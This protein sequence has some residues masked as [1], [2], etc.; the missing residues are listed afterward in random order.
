MVRSLTGISCGVVIGAV[1]PHALCVVAFPVT[2]LVFCGLLVGVLFLRV[3]DNRGSNFSVMFPSVL[4]GAALA[5]ASNT[6][7]SLAYDSNLL[8]VHLRQAGSCR[9]RVRGRIVQ[10][11]SVTGR[12]VSLEVALQDTL[13]SSESEEKLVLPDVRGWVRVRITRPRHRSEEV[14]C[15]YGELTGVYAYGDVV[16]ING[17]ASLPEPPRNPNAFSLPTYF[18]EQR[19]HAELTADIKDVRI[20]ARRV[21]NPV[22]A[23]ALWLKRRLS[24]V[25]ADAV[26]VPSAQ[27]AM[28]A[29]LGDR[30][31]LAGKTFRNRG[32]LA[33]FERAGISHVLAVSGLHVGIVALALYRCGRF[34][35]L[36]PKALTPVVIV[37]LCMLTVMTGA[38]PATVRAAIMTS[39]AFTAHAWC[40]MKPRYAGFTGVGVAGCVIVLWN[41]LL[42]FSPGFQLSFAAVLSLLLLTPPL[43]RH[44]RSLTGAEIAFVSLWLCAVLT[45]M[46]R[47]IH[48]LFTPVGGIVS[49][50]GFA[51]A[52][53]TGR[54]LNAEHPSRAAMLRMDRLPRGVTLFIA[55]Q[56]AIQVGAILPL[57]AWYFGRY[58]VA[59]MFVNFAAIPLI[60]LFVQMALLTGIAGMLPFIGGW[61]AIPLGFVTSALGTGFFWLAWIGAVLFP[62]PAVPKPTLGGVAAYYCGLALLWLLCETSHEPV[63]TTIAADTVTSAM[64]PRLRTG[65]ALALGLLAIGSLVAGHYSHRPGRP[66]LTVLHIQAAPR[67]PAYPACCGVAADGTGFLI[68]GGDRYVAERLVFRFYTWAGVMHVPEIVL[69]TEHTR[70]GLGAVAALQDSLRIATCRCPAV[71]VEALSA[72]L[73][74]KDAAGI[75]IIENAAAP[76]G[77][78]VA[79]AI[80]AEGI[81]TVHLGQCRITVLTDTPRVRD[82]DALETCDI[83][84]LPW[85]V[86]A[87]EYGGTSKSTATFRARV[88]HVLEKCRPGCIILTDGRTRNGFDV[89]DWCR[90][91]PWNPRL[92]RTTDHGAITIEPGPS[93][94]RLIGYAPKLNVESNRTISRPETLYTHR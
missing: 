73:K 68:N 55:A 89:Y 32:I 78:N 62:Y 18:R 7:G 9:V 87:F 29:T 42:L 41:P 12:G 76:T 52:K 80:V 84:V 57:S 23:A 91:L 94:Y 2:A 88:E 64:P 83:L 8:R 11:P 61:L 17:I 50:L 69:N 86:G 4:V 24:A 5:L 71:T 67:R 40:G 77:A 30:A 36:S 38:R 10:E 63:E 26:S 43:H 47:G 45:V 60:A 35:R 3:R 85:Q 22:V 49:V 92:F 93:G 65:L 58:S 82:I 79:V 75:R 19:L 44:L 25:Y 1:L 20:V 74:K 81:T 54:K 6:V 31:A 28:G 21:G 51:L 16:D 34:A 39:L 13:V 70:A 15:R 72:K 59:G 90:R 53:K 56:A 33:L 46:Y 27:L 48:W 37:A 14:H 66:S